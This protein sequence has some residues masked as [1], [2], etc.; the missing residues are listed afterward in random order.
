MKPLTRIILA[1]ASGLMLS[2]PW[3]GF[4]GWILFFAWIPLLA[5]DGFLHAEKSGF[6]SVIFPFYAFIAFLAWNVMTTWWIV[7]ATAVGALLAIL[8]NSLLMSLVIWIVHLLRRSST[9]A[10]GYVA[11]IVM[12]LAFEFFHFH[13]D[14]EWPWL[15]LGNGFANDVKFV[16][17]YEYTGVLGGSLWILVVN[18]MLYRLFL[19]LLPGSGKGNILRY[20]IPVGLVVFIPGVLSLIS[21]YTYSEDGEQRRILIVQPN[22]DPYS[23]AFDAGAVNDKLVK[24]IRLAEKEIDAEIDYIIGPETV[25]EQDWD[26][27][28]LLMYPAF[29]RLRQIIAPFDRQSLII[30]ASTYRI[31]TSE[32]QIPATARKSS[33]GSYAYDRFNTAIFTDRYGEYQLYHKSILVS[34]VEKMPFRK[35]LR[36]L[37]KFII[38]LGGTT[39][40]LGVQEYPENFIAAN[41]DRKKIRT[42]SIA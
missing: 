34:G 41:G 29:D 38:D 12:W 21:Y 15:T 40:S 24:F 22:I 7:Y 13:W 36:F 2:L 10:L 20:V 18:I 5:L 32:D 3:L 26:E 11:W 25:F 31:Y 17:W 4:P 42:N 27:A 6:R 39:G 1:L 28:R 35:Y 23:E 14:I 33:D 37:E 19:R 9:G 16:Q 8:L 30:G